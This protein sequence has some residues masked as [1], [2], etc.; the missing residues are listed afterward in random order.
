MRECVKCGTAGLAID[1]YIVRRMS[2]ACRIPKATE[3][4]IIF[5]TYCLSTATVA[6]QT[7]VNVMF[8]IYIAC[9][10][11]HAEAISNVLVQSADAIFWM[12]VR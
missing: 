7:C 8:F 2:F 12:S 4:L 1:D 6:M 10:V 9:L 3:T 11:L 5:N